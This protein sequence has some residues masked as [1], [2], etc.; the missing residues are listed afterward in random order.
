MKKSV[1]SGRQAEQEEICCLSKFEVQDQ[2]NSN[3]ENHNNRANYP[4]VLAHP[5]CHGCQNF[6]ALTYVVIHSV[7]LQ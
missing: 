7:K 3:D 2:G 4:L 5:P 1:S 6:L